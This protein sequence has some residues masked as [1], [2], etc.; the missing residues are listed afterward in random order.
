M[1]EVKVRDNERIDDLQI[2]GLKI[3]QNTDGFCFGIDAV[4]LANFC[5]VKRG[6]TV[7]DLGTGTGIIPI[8]VAGKSSADKIYGVEIQEE[9][10]EMASR[11][12]L[13]NDLSP[14]VE[15]LNMDLKNIVDSLGKGKVDVVISNPPYMHPNGLINEND[16]KAISRHCIKCDLEDVVRVASELLKPNG[17]FFMVNRPNRLV[18]I[19]HYGRMYKLEP[20]IIRFVHSRVS[21]APKLV[22]VEY[23]KLAKPEVKILDPL[24]IYKNDNEYTDEINEIYKKESIE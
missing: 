15:I 13:M 2:K 3:I 9:V 7:V 12:V 18:D 17:S 10:A 4:L 1:K 23:K 11:S 5:K 8:L 14:R 19:L 6:S 16:K 20:K 21:N 24:Y 22:L